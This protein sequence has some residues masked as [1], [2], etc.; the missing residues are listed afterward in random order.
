MEFYAFHRLF[1]RSLYHS[2]KRAS[3]SLLYRGTMNDYIADDGLVRLDLDDKHPPFSPEFPHTVKNENGLCFRAEL[4]NELR[5]AGA[6]LDRFKLQSKMAV[7]M[8]T[9]ILGITHRRPGQTGMTN[10]HDNKV[11][12]LVLLQIHGEQDLINKSY[13][14]LSRRLWIYNNTGR[15]GIKEIAETFMIPRDRALYR[16]AAKRPPGII[17]FIWLYFSVYT[18]S[19]EKRLVH[20]R[21]AS[22]ELS[23]KHSLFAKILYRRYRKW[24]EKWGGVKKYSHELESYYMDPNQPTRVLVKAR[25]NIDK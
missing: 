14:N 12:E 4:I 21:M 6:N 18:K 22:L 16:M 8:C 15:W 19:K 9:E 5:L 25:S 20:L 7:L 10:S 23:S 11:G 13:V 17:A 1:N 24:F 2:L 3:S